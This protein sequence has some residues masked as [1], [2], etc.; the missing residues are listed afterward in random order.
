MKSGPTERGPFSV[1]VDVHPQDYYSTVYRP[2]P[3]ARKKTCTRERMFLRETGSVL[4]PNDRRMATRMTPREQ[5]ELNTLLREMEEELKNF[6]DYHEPTRSTNNNIYSTPNKFVRGSY[7]TRSFSH[8]PTVKSK[9]LI[10]QHINP[11]LVETSS[12]DSGIHP[13]VHTFREKT[14]VETTQL[15]T[16]VETIKPGVVQT[17]RRMYSHP[18]RSPVYSP[19]TTTETGIHPQNLLHNSISHDRSAIERVTTPTY[20]IGIVSSRGVERPFQPRYSDR[21]SVSSPI[22]VAR[23]VTLTP[24]AMTTTTKPVVVKDSHGSQFAARATQWY[25]EEVKE[26]PPM[27]LLSRPRPYLVN[28]DSK[29]FTYGV[30]SATPLIQRRRV[31]SESTAYVSENRPNLT[32]QEDQGKR[33]SLNELLN[34]LLSM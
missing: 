2:Q 27:H 15:S 13:P 7:Q 6:S 4:V 29:P 28:A 25:P 1:N 5:Q 3:P 17:L 11:S 24:T 23:S 16:G 8:S 19:T 21:S 33:D 12:V 14:R 31:H 30:T 34:K 32:Q 18:D 10:L 26:P 22:D 9:P 20:G